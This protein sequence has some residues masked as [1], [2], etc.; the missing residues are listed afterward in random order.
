MN[1]VVYFIYFMSLLSVGIPFVLFYTL[2]NWNDNTQNK[3]GVNEK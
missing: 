1:I 3:K 2:I